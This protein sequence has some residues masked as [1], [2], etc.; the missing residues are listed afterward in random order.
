MPPCLTL[1]VHLVS[2]SFLP[3]HVSTLWTF[4]STDLQQVLSLRRVLDI[5][6]D[7]VPPLMELCFRAVYPFG[8]KIPRVVH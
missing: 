3:F 1:H 4:F 7:S 2:T 5:A 8:K 6:C